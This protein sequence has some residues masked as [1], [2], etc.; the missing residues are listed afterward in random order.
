MNNGLLSVPMRKDWMNGYP[1]V[2][3]SCKRGG[4]VACGRYETAKIGLKSMNSSV[5][6]KSSGLTTHFW[7]EFVTVVGPIYM[8]ILD[9]QPFR[10]I[11][12][13]KSTKALMLM[14]LVVQ[15]FGEHM[16]PLIV[17]FDMTAA[18]SD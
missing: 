14:R 3:K 11:N 7:L 15:S 16:H 6:T 10:S 17:I 2:S 8:L 1:C 13:S 18:W 5:F 9:D 4:N 12:L